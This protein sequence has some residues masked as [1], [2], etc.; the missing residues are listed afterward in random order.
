MKS[1]QNKCACEMGTKPYKALSLAKRASTSDSPLV[2]KL[3]TAASAEVDR[4]AGGSAPT[5]TSFSDTLTVSLS[6]SRSLSR[7]EAWPMG[8][9]FLWPN[10]GHTAALGQAADGWPSGSLRASLAWGAF[11]AAE[12]PPIFSRERD[13]WIG[14]L[15]FSVSGNQEKRSSEHNCAN[16]G[17]RRGL[18]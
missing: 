12:T 6:I 18:N 9:L 15:M 4:K 8:F 13:L 11:T 1:F 16:E 14:V 10:S 2:L 3:L 17:A 7:Q 5:C